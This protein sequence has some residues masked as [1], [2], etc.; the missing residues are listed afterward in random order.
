MLRDIVIIPATDADEIS[1]PEAD[2]LSFVSSPGGAHQ[3]TYG[4]PPILAPGT[5]EFVSARQQEGDVTVV[6]VNPANITA[7]K[8]TKV[9]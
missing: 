4:K 1:W 7:M 6:Y 5:N 9:A 8:A 3:G 2:F